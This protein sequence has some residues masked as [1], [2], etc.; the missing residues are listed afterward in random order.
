[1]ERR[2]AKEGL[3]IRICRKSFIR[4][5][6]THSL[7][8]VCLSSEDKKIIYLSK[9][10][11]GKEHDK[12]IFLNEK[13]W[14]YLPDK[15]KKYFDSAF[16]VLEKDCPEMA[17]IKKPTKRKRGQRELSKT[18]KEQN[19][20]IS[21]KRVLIENSFAGVKRLK[22]TWDIFRNHKKGFSDKIFW[23]ACYVWNFHLW[24]QNP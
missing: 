17:N 18:I 11:P 8:N 1:M 5:K 13:L 22:I 23:I 6:K 19:K 16:E 3:K 20:R 9:T 24:I 4:V 14:K 15:I 12:T 10:Y 21:R 2:D 7:K